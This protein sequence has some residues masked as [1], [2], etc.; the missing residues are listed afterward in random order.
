MKK[1]A[2][3]LF[4]SIA[5]TLQAADFERIYLSTDRSA[6]VAGDLVWCSAFSLGGTPVHS[7]V[8][9]V[10]LFSTDGTAAQ[11]KIAMNGGRG[12]GLIVLPASLPTGNYLLCAYTSPDDDPAEILRNGRVFATQRGYG[13]WKDYWEFPGGKIEP[14]ETPEEALAR[15]IREE[16]DTVIA[17]GGK[18]ASV[19][20]DYPAFRLSMDCFFAEVLEGDLILKEHEAARWLDRE[21]LESVQWLPADLEVLKALRQSL[22]DA[23]GTL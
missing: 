11:S 3:L 22:S 10:E 4:L 8:V 6:Y 18:L 23:D 13:D 14:G 1:I 19:V 9:Y 12:S 15:E 21:E 16:L 20:Y 17:V 7:G 2:V 5:L